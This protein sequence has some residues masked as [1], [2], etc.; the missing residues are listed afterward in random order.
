MGQILR[1]NSYTNLWRL[2]SDVQEA[3]RFWSDLKERLEQEWQQ[4]ADKA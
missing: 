3:R 2:A 1:R 4:A